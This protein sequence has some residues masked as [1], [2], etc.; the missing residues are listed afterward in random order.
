MEIITE[1]KLVANFNMLLFNRVTSILSL[2]KFYYYYLY[3]ERM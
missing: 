1:P 3:F 2:K